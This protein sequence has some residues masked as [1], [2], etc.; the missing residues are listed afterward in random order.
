MDS[1]FPTII[2]EYAPWLPA[3]GQK[4]HVYGKEVYEDLLQLS[5][6]SSHYTYSSTDD[7]EL[8]LLLVRTDD[9]RY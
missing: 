1:H 7:S 8:P 4:Y 3:S 6:G 5:F 2:Q 9:F